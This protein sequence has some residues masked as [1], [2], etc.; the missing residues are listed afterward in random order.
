MVSL[1]LLTCFI[2]CALALPHVSRNPES[3]S[4]KRGL[5]RGFDI[6]IQR[7]VDAGRNS[8]RGDISGSVGMGNNAD[9]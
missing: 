4:A 1:F 9:V 2:S 3:S 8:K 7:R 5:V 6:P